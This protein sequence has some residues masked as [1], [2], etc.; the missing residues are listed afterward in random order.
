MIKKIKEYFE[1]KK[2]LRTV[3]RN[4][5][6]FGSTA[7]PLVNLV[8]KNALGLVNFAT[9]VLDECSN[10]KEDELLDRLQLIIKDSTSV[11]ADK[12]ETDEA[13]LFE[14]VKYIVTLDI[15]DIQKIIADAQVET[16]NKDK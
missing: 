7:L 2:N 5:V 6:K 3:K 15:T 12:F 16:M 11:L 10:L 13:R 4:I 1:Y 9:R 8:T 14:I